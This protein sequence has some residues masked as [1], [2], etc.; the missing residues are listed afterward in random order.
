MKVRWYVVVALAGIAAAAAGASGC[1]RAAPAGPTDITPRVSSATGNTSQ[2]LSVAIRADSAVLTLPGQ[3]SLSAIEVLSN[4]TLDVTS[5][6]VWSSD[7]TRV[8]TV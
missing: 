4:G 2:V 1:R 3:T 5:G 6:A 8:A 7:N